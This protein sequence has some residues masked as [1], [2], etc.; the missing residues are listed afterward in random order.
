MH[1]VDQSPMIV[2]DKRSGRRGCAGARDAGRSSGS[3]MRSAQTAQPLMDSLAEEED[4]VFVE[5]Q[6]SVNSSGNISRSR[7]WPCSPAVP[8]KFHCSSCE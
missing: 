8:G 4:Y 3:S 1:K 7:C 6:T 5:A 2:H